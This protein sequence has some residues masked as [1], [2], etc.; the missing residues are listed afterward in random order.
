MEFYTPYI[1]IF[2]SF[3]IIILIGAVTVCSYMLPYLI[4]KIRNHN[5]L[6]A[7]GVLNIL[8]GWTLL[9]WIVAIVWAC[10][11]NVSPKQAKSRKKLAYNSQQ[12]ANDDRFSRMKP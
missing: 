4:A 5:Q 8:A 1:K 2:S 12:E 9:G 7:I 10:T 11:S 6:L 3:F